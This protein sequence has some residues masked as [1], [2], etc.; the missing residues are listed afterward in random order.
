MSAWQAADFDGKLSADVDLTFLTSSERSDG[1]GIVTSLLSLYERLPNADHHRHIAEEGDLGPDIVEALVEEQCVCV[2]DADMEKAMHCAWP[3]YRHIKLKEVKVDP[4]AAVYRQMLF[5][6]TCELLSGA[7]YLVFIERLSLGLP[8][9]FNI[10]GKK[11]VLQETGFVGGTYDDGT[12]AYMVLQ[13]YDDGCSGLL[14]DETHQWLRLKCQVVG[15]SELVSLDLDPS[16]LQYSQPQTL[17]PTGSLPAYNQL[18]PVKGEAV[19]DV[20]A[21]IIRCLF[22]QFRQYRDEQCRVSS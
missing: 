9:F 17:F 2:D 16:S 22:K 3:R 20:V 15:S 1:Q 13:F 4:E 21:K 6:N 5:A 10:D 14:A 18:E 19:D 11:V 12:R 8:T 7:L